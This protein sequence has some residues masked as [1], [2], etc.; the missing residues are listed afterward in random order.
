MG[1]AELAVNHSPEG[2]SP[3]Y[4]T[5]PELEPNPAKYKKGSKRYQVHKELNCKPDIA[6]ASLSRRGSGVDCKSTVI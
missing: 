4:A 3:S 1:Y 6:H 5:A 2:S